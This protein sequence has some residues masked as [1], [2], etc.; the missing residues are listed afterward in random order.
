MSGTYKITRAGKE[1]QADLFSIR[2]SDGTTKIAVGQASA[3]FDPWKMA[4]VPAWFAPSEPRKG[5]K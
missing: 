2:L 3:S 1:P 4:E 5:L